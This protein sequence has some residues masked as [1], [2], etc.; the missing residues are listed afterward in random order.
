MIVAVVGIAGSATES[1]LGRLTRNDEHR[2][3]LDLGAIVVVVVIVITTPFVSETKW[4]RE[5]KRVRLRGP[6][7]IRT[8]ARAPSLIAEG[9]GAAEPGDCTDTDS[10]S[11]HFFLFQN[12]ISRRERV[13]GELKLLIKRE[14]RMGKQ[15]AKAD[16]KVV[17]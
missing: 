15:K 5:A 11:Q 1:S 13:R 8:R 4:A 3:R 9:G 6:T 12:L 7:R 10:S 16:G 2:L 14:E 17:V